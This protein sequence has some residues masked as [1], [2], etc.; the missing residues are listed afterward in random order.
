MIPQHRL[1]KSPLFGTILEY[2]NSINTVDDTL[3]IFVPYIQTKILSKLLQEVSSKI[4]VVTTWRPEDLISGSSELSLYHY[5]K[6]RG[7]ALYI[8]NKI[9]LKI[10]S[11][12]L[13][14]IV[15]TTANLSQRALLDVADANLECAIHMN[16]LTNED[17]LFFAQIQ[18]NAIHVNERVYEIFSSWYDKQVKRERI[19]DTLQPIIEKWDTRDFLIS[20]LPM[21][22]DPDI[23]IKSY[24]RINQGLIAN[25]NQETR[26]CIFHDL[27]NYNIKFGLDE[28]QFRA[29]LTESFFQHPFIRK[30]DE[31][32][33]SE[34]YFG[35][36]KEWI[37]NNCK[38]V[39]VPSRRELTGNVQVL[40]RWFEEL[41]GGKYVVDIPGSY[42]Q[43]IRRIKA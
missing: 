43:R 39:P 42:S 36:I 13:N 34:S 11:V 2:V 6:E 17:R 4:V 26:D 22:K 16:N 35:R 14:D 8:N 28:D 23:L 40:F 24:Y 37:Q 29:K 30:I 1:L 41:G 9:H 5:C 33:S 27:A 7:I 20:A 21:T 10:Y 18:N 12:A 31:F 3:F 19:T 15:L 38:D 32:I 25:E